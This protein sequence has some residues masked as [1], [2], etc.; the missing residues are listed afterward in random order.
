MKISQPLIFVPNMFRIICFS[1]LR[2]PIQTLHINVKEK[3][4]PLLAFVLKLLSSL[5]VSCTA[6]L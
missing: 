2:T 3:Q 6:L 5:I 1:S 4:S